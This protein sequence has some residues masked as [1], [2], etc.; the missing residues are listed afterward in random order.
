MFFF[1]VYFCK[2]IVYT[3][4]SRTLWWHVSDWFWL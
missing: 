4:I 2:N 1:E 3:F